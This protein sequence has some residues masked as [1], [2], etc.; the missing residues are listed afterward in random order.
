MV[1]ELSVEEDVAPCHWSFEKLGFDQEWGLRDVE[2]FN[3]KLIAVRTQR[4]LCGL[5]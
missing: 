2:V 3:D 1:G 5:D 4:V